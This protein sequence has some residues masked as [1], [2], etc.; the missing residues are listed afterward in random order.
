MNLNLK[1]EDI[2]VLKEYYAPMLAEAQ[3]KVDEIL[4]GYTELKTKLDEAQAIVNSLQDKISELERR[5]KR[6]IE[7]KPIGGDRPRRI[8][9]TSIPKNKVN[10]PV[11]TDMT[12]QGIEAAI[13]LKYWTSFIMEA[14]TEQDRLLTTNDLFDLSIEH[15]ELDEDNM[16]QGKASLSRAIHKLANQKKLLVKYPIIGK[17]GYYY[18]LPEWFNED[19]RPVEEYA[20]DIHVV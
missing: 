12:I 7:G 13:P 16:R 10:V 19:G 18:G 9:N 14:I 17:K 1:L 3:A 4:P 5:E 2:K 20:G 15:F 6:I 11:R 8:F